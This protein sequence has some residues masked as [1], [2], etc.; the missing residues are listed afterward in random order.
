MMRRTVMCLMLALS[1]AVFGACRNN[2]E[3]AVE[4]AGKK[5][6]DAVD[7]VK[8]GESPFHKKGAAEKAGEAVD[9]A[10]HGENR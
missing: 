5:V 4:R 7:N 2:N 1:I 10:I 9:D 3:G 6:D 8:D